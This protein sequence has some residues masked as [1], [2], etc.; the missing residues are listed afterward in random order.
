VVRW[1]NLPVESGIFVVSVEAGSPAQKAGVREGD[2][3]IGYNDQTVPDIDALH[4][5]LTES[6]LG[7]RA[8]LAVV[9]GTEK[10]AL[11]VVPAESPRTAK[12]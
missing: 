8:T 11:D 7:V 2:I 9:R 5:I 3:L 12:S 1:H 10:L 6:R 4:R